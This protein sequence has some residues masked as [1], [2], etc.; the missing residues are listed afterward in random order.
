MSGLV[1]TLIRWVLR[2]NVGS[3]PTITTKGYIEQLVGSL[4]CKTSPKGVV[5][6]IHL[7]PQNEGVVE[8]S[9]AGGCN[10]SFRGFESLHLLNLE[11]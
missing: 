4:V 11:L 1:T 8:W 3:N 6:R 5:V 9:K 7:Y 10:P 2:N